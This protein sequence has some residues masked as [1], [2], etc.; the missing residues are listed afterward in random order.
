M[1]YNSNYEEELKDVRWLKKRIEILTKANFRCKWCG[2]TYDLQVHHKKYKKGRRPWEYSN[3]ELVCICG[4][5]HELEHDKKPI[6]LKGMYLLLPLAYCEWA[7][8]YGLPQVGPIFYSGDVYPN[9]SK[10]LLLT[11]KGCLEESI[12][13]FINSKNTARISNRGHQL[14]YVKSTK[15]FR[16]DPLAPNDTTMMYVFDNDDYSPAYVEFTKLPT[17]EY[18]IAVISIDERNAEGWHKC[19]LSELFSN[20]HIL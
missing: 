4:N 1:A 14:S 8:A 2:S 5:C 20:V 16:V 17:F 6:L 19:S 3:E 11:R 7:D 9:Q 18:D 15:P 10:Y 12:G 13:A